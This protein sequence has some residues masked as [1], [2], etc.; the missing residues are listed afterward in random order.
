MAQWMVH[1]MVKWMVRWMAGWMARRMEDAMSVWKAN[2]M[3]PPSGLFALT[4]F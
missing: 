2:T 4:P 1:T 3:A